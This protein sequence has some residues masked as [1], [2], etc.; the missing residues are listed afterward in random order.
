MSELPDKGEKL[1]A[2]IDNISRLIRDLNLKIS[3]KLTQLNALAKP[4]MSLL[5]CNLSEVDYSVIP[6]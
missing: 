2:H 6:L 1:R 4:G 3:S 5:H